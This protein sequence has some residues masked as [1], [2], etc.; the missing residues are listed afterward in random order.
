[1]ALLQTMA[2]M[3]QKVRYLHFSILK[4]LTKIIQSWGTAEGVGIG[5]SQ[6][7]QLGHSPDGSAANY[8]CHAPKGKMSSLF[9][10]YVSK[11]SDTKFSVNALKFKLR[12][13]AIL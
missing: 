3:H 5:E 8:G 9:Y 11:F 13:P 6:V 10:R 7:Q 4:F 2:V 12:G 1:M